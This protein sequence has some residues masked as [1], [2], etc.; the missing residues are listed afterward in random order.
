MTIEIFTNQEIARTPDRPLGEISNFVTETLPSKLAQIRAGNTDVLDL[1]NFISGLLD[2]LDQNQIEYLLEL[3]GPV[4]SFAGSYPYDMRLALATLDLKMLEASIVHSGGI[5]DE[6]LI[7]L[8]DKFSEGVGQLP[9]LTYEELVY[10][11]PLQSDPRV[12]SLGDV[13]NHE[14]DFYYGHRLIEAQ[15]NNGIRHIHYLLNNND[16]N[17][18]RD[19][20]YINACV[21][22]AVNTMSMYH[23]VFNPDDFL[24]FRGYLG[25]HPIRNLKGGSGAFSPAVPV[26]EL[27][28]NRASLE[29][30]DF[31]YLEKNK[32]Y[33]PIQGQREI[34]DAMRMNQDL[35]TKYPEHAEMIGQITTQVRRFR[36]HHYR[37]VNTHIPQALEGD[38][39]GTAGEDPK[40][41]LKRRINRT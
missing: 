11:N 5:P 18:L 4:T 2:N 19:M 31:E 13:S 14:R 38:L 29:Q 25:S 21:D 35:I 37:A 6:R 23:R 27:I 39:T 40:T 12:F 26:L 17:V 20:N 7:Q 36:A 32:R 16:V 15:L 34:D 1:S 22:R 41:F 3:S 28:L 30:T 33:F 9:V 10:V 8:V 24:E